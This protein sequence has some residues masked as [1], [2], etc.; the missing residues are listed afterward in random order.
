VRG[1][2]RPMRTAPAGSVKQGAKLGVQ[3]DGL[4]SQNFSG[5]WQRSRSDMEL[6]QNCS[7]L[8]RFPLH[9]FEIKD[10]RVWVTRERA[11]TYR[12]PS[13]QELKGSEDIQV[14]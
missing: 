7:H 5:G 13:E 3:S 1:V 4:A 8:L 10:R 11:E 12:R 14:A 9:D 6:S 2:K